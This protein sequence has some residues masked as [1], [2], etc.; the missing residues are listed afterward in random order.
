MTIDRLRSETKAAHQALEKLIIPQIKNIRNNEDYIRLLELFYGYFYPIEKLIDKHLDT[1]LVPDYNNRRKATRLI[2]DIYASGGRPSHET[3]EDLPEITSTAEALG[4]MYVLEGSTLGGKII[5]KMI[6]QN[7]SLTNE[8][9]VSFF[10]GY[11]DA[12]DD[13]WAAFT[14][15]LNNYTEDTATQSRIVEAADATFKKFINW[16]ELSRTAR[17]TTANAAEKL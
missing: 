9:A 6:V 11:G 3:A 17:E 14:Q 13:M 16:V 2:Q 1:T 4:A 8:D 10:K 5:S 12:S 7:L 15:V